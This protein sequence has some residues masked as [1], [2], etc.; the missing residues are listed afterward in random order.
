MNTANLDKL[1]AH[2]EAMPDK[3]FD[4][5][6]WMEGPLYEYGGLIISDSVIAAEVLHKQ[7]TTGGCG[8][9]ACIA[10]EAAIL[11]VA[12]KAADVKPPLSVSVPKLAQEWL[13]LTD[14]QA[15]TLFTPGTYYPRSEVTKAQALAVLKAL[16]A[17]G[18]LSERSWERVGVWMDRYH[19]GVYHKGVYY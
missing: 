18:R 9:V 2:M 10:G 16:R 12:E 3:A 17:T 14:L 15:D 13:N 19:K 5:S 6:K 1:I 4:L 7:R 11:A 8:T